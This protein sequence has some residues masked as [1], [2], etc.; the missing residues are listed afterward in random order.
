MVRL[1][2]Q[3]YDWHCPLNGRRP[4]GRIGKKRSVS[5]SGAQSAEWPIRLTGRNMYIVLHLRIHTVYVC[6]H[7]TREERGVQGR[8]SNNIVIIFLVFI[9]SNCFIFKLLYSVRP[10]YWMQ[11][12]FCNLFGQLMT[13]MQRK[14]PVNVAGGK[15]AS[16]LLPKRQ[17]SKMKSAVKQCL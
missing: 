2:G 11:W 6:I 8:S 3:S 10:I 13:S 15:L 17:I 14:S 4:V 12:R 1:D 16:Q 5:R 7:R 9:L